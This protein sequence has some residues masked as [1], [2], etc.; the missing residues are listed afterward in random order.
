[1]AVVLKDRLG[2]KIGEIRQKR[3]EFFWA[4]QG[5]YGQAFGCGKE[6]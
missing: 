4:V 1:M 3:G 6:S 2:R 5:P